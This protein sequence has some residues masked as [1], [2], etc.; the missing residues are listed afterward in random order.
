MLNSGEFSSES[1]QLGLVLLSYFA[2]LG[3][4]FIERLPDDA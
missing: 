2:V 1:L 4:E 3:F